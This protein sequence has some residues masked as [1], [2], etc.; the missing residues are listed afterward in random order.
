[1]YNWSL[2]SEQWA[3]STIEQTNS[4]DTGMQMKQQRMIGGLEI[5][6]KPLIEEHRL[7]FN[8]DWEHSLSAQLFLH[9]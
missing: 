8:A 7:D 9:C 1:M 2:E 4:I 3:I 6:I 5:E